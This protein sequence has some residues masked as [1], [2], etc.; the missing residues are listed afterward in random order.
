MI[1]NPQP[2]IDKIVKRLKQKNGMHMAIFDKEDIME[3]HKT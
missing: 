2:A 3:M 1:K